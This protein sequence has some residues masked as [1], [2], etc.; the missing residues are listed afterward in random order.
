M[1][2]LPHNIKFTSEKEKQNPIRLA[3]SILFLLSY[4][5]VRGVIDCGSLFVISPHHK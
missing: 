1:K 4:L 3:Y 2:R 5:L